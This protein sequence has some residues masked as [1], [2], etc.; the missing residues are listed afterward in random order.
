MMYMTFT[1]LYSHNTDKYYGIIQTSIMA[2]IMACEFSHSFCRERL[3]KVPDILNY[4]REIVL[5]K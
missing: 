3:E 5:V 1:C 2:S 4:V